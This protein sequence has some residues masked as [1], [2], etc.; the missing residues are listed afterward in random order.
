MQNIHNSNFKIGILGGGQL[1]RMTLQEAYNLNLHIAVLDPSA[2][3]PCK[4]L[5][6]E[7]V[8]GDFKDFDAVY[9]FWKRQRHNYNRV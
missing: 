7:F 2:E 8:Q 6:H 1:G 5:A 4:D 3:A 9:D